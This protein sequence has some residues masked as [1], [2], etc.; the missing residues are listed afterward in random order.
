MPHPEIK[1]QPKLKFKKKTSAEVFVFI[2]LSLIMAGKT[3]LTLVLFLC[4]LLMTEPQHTQTKAVLDCPGSRLWDLS[5]PQRNHFD[6]HVGRGCCQ[7]LLQQG[8]FCSHEPSA[9]RSMLTESVDFLKTTPVKIQV[10]EGTVT[11]YSVTTARRLFVPLL[12]M[13]KERLERKQHGVPQWHLY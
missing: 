10:K 7:W 11:L 13:V 12:P 5:S 1:K 2:Q 9:Q 6:G 8:S 4:T 3:L